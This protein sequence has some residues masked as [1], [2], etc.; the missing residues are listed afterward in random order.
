MQLL[1]KLK[2][3]IGAEQEEEPISPR[4][5]PIVSPPTQ[6]P[7]DRDATRPSYR[8]VDQKWRKIQKAIDQAG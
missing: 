4:V 5:E 8:I 3:L 6:S 7:K 1:S 2:E